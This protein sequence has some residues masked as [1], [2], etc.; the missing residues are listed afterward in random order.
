MVNRLSSEAK[1][2]VGHRFRPS[3]PIRQRK[4][5]R[6]GIF[7]LTGGIAKIPLAR[8]VQKSRDVVQRA[9]RNNAVV[10]GAENKRDQPSDHGAPDQPVNPHA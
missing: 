9:A 4:E 6:F 8:Q 3:N 2:P 5:A 1:G 10:D 7:H